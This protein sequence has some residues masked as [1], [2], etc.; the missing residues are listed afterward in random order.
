MFGPRSFTQAARRD[1]RPRM[2]TQFTLV[3]ELR[4]LYNGESSILSRDFSVASDGTKYVLKHAALMIPFKRLAIGRRPPRK[5][6]PVISRSLLWASTEGRN[7]FLSP[8]SIFCFVAC[9]RGGGGFR[10]AGPRIYSRSCRIS[11]KGKRN[12]EIDFRIRAV[13]FGARRIRIGA[14][15]CALPWRRRRTLFK[16]ARSFATRTR[17]ARCSRSRRTPR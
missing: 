17:R 3:D 14:S 1:R 5:T 15:R 13:S 6:F 12:D 10:R 8:R 16:F 7:F 11:P 2:S 9:G 4:E